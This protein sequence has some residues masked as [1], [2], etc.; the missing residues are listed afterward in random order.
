MYELEQRILLDELRQGII[1]DV[2]VVADVQTM[3]ANPLF[4]KQP[5]GE[6]LRDR[7]NARVAREKDQKRIP[8]KS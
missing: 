7:L 2:D 3:R 4:W 5:E 6:S 1:L 8:Q